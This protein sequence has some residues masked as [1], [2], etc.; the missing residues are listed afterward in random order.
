[1]RQKGGKGTGKNVIKATGRQSRLRITTREVMITPSKQHDATKRRISNIACGEQHCPHSRHTS[2]KQ[3]GVPNL[4]FTKVSA[5]LVGLSALVFQVLS[6]D[7]GDTTLQHGSNAEAGT[8]NLREQSEGGGR[9]GGERCRSTPCS[10]WH[11][12]WRCPCGASGGRTWSR[13]ACGGCAS[14]ENTWQS[15]WLR[16]RSSVHCA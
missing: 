3:G 14:F 6:G 9:G 4:G 1:M 2:I 7:A 11:P 16:T 8:A 5:A 12:R 15:S 13:A 10:S